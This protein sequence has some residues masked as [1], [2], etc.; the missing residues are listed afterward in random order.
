MLRVTLDIVP[1]GKEAC[2]RTI[3]TMVV[4]RLRWSSA[5]INPCDYNVRLE[6]DDKE[7]KSVIARGH[8]YEDGAWLLVRRALEALREAS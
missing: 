1:F 7:V 6:T 2:K 3:G 4:S 8:Y 5:G